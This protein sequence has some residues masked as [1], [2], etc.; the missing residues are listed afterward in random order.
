MSERAG[1]A[2]SLHAKIRPAMLLGIVMIIGHKTLPAEDQII[3]RKCRG[4]LIRDEVYQN[5]TQA[6]NSAAYAWMPQKPKSIW[7]D[8]ANFA[9]E[10][11]PNLTHEL[12][13]L[14]AMECEHVAYNT[15][16]TDYADPAEGKVR[17]KQ[18]SFEE[19][20]AKLTDKYSKFVISGRKLRVVA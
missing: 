4:N 18:V 2:A 9:L 10:W 5:F 11:K 16:H 14:V 15:A 6:G 8:E 13:E 17:H 3:V 19:M 20:L 7:L 1:G 12:A